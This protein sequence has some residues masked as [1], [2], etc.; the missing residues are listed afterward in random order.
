M[1]KKAA[2]FCSSCL[3]LSW[4]PQM[5]RTDAMPKPWLSIPDLAAAIS[6]GWLA[7]PR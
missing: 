6:A 2:S 1:P 5:K 3:W 4:V 7:R